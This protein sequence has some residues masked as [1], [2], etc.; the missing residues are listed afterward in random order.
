MSH[1]GEA[2][3]FPHPTLSLARVI[4]WAQELGFS[5]VSAVPL[6]S[7]A[8]AMPM[9]AFGQWLE[10]GFAGDMRYLARNRDLRARPENLLP[11]AQTVLMVTMPYLPSGTHNHW[12]DA[13]E[14][15]LGTPSRAVI[16]VYALGRDYHKV[17]RGRL[18]ALADRCASF[19]GGGRFRACVD[20]APLLEVELAERAGLGWRGKNTLLLNQ[21]QGSMF[22]L[23]ALLTSLRF[24]ASVPDK[25]DRH[26]GTCTACLDL[27]PTQAF[28]GPYQLDARRCI[29]YLTI[30]HEG[31]IPEALRPLMG[32]RVYGCDDCQRVCPWNRFAECATLPDFSVRHGLDQATLIALFAWS[33]QQFHDRHQGSAIRRIGYARWLRNLAVG[34]GNALA[35]AVQ[36]ADDQ[37]ALRIR[38]ALEA[39]RGDSDAMVAR[40]VAWALAQ[41]AGI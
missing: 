2:I 35:A 18:A 23:G 21:D 28:V 38:S 10:Q 27:C 37:A 16:S 31:D 12:R 41:G 32:N 20:S 40:H 11:D 8:K 5:S 4:G 24:P 33:E 1:S 34:L 3:D 25:T 19:Y 36:A 7:E 15:A 39:R 14:A 17:M 9:D 26:C 30:E 29:S 6:G 13:Q 22:F